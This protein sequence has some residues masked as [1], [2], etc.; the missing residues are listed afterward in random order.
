MQ[1]IW[2]TVKIPTVA[3]APPEVVELVAR[4]EALNLTSILVAL[5]IIGGAWM[6]SRFVTTSLDRFGEGQ[7]RRRLAVKRVQSVVRLA[8][9]VGAAYLV[10]G[11]F[12]DFEEDRAA[13]LGMG[14]VLALALGFALKDTTSSLMAGIM[15]LID[16]PF[17]VG[18]RVIFGS[19]S[20]EVTEIGLRS[21]RLKTSDARQISIPNNLFLTQAVISANVGALD[22]MVPIN[23]YIAATADFDVAKQIVYE[24]C[25]TSRYVYLNKPVEIFIEDEVTNLGVATR[26]QACVYVSDTR[27]ESA[28]RSDLTERVKRAFR[29]HQI[30]GPYRQNV[31]VSAASWSEYELE[32]TKEAEEARQ[33]GAQNRSESERLRGHSQ[34]LEAIPEERLEFPDEETG[35]QRGA[36]KKRK[37][38]FIRPSLKV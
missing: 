24:A 36:L 17:H 38:I 19:Y 8:I 22:M 32:R 26:L 13:L 25:I 10:L 33:R 2:S 28:M 14:G 4:L 7:A 34:R 16:Q 11:T 37:K 35:D 6:T 29:V 21:V 27:Y 23:F 9:F 18:D 12:F 5:F 31:S 15:I 1:Q 3:Q 20:G 30:H